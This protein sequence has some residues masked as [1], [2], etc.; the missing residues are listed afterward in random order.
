MA[1]WFQKLIGSDGST[2]LGINASAPVGTEGGAVTRPV[3]R[4]K[5]TTETTAN[6]GIAGVYT[7]SWNDTQLEGSL[8][9]QATARSDQV[10]AAAGFS[11]EESDDTADA[12]F[13]TVAN[14]VSVAASATTTL[15]APIK[16]RY[17]RIK[18][19]NGGV[20]TTAFKI[21]STSRNMA[22][23]QAGDQ[24]VVI[25]AQNSSTTNLASAATFTGV[26]DSTL[27]SGAIQVNLFADQ[28]CTIN[29]DQSQDGTNW[30]TTDTYTYL[31][32]SKA[33]D[34]GRTTQ[35]TGAYVRVRVTNNGG[36]STTSFR[37][38]TVL[39]PIIEAMPRSLNQSGSLKTSLQ[40][41]GGL[42]YYRITATSGTMAAA[43]AASAQVF[44][45]RWTNA[46]NLAIIT[47]VRVSVRAL[48]PFTA[49]T[50]TD[51]GMDLYKTTSVSAG[52]GGTTLGAP[53]KM[54]TNMATSLVANINI[55]TTAALTAATTVDASAICASLGW[56]Q[57]VNPAAATEE[58]VNTAPILLFE[59]KL[60]NG[61]HP[62]V[63][64]TNEGIVIRNRTIWPAAGTAL[65][66]VEIG[67]HEAPT[68]N[69]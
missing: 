27:G 45:F 46:S 17:W 14:N 7:G 25:S 20:A 52:G 32:S 44:Q 42:G 24:A 61:E 58:V 26:D 16:R 68:Y 6:L 19:T 3:L 60:S 34:S 41:M 35:A 59:P 50:L 15:D 62:L 47:Y 29:I 31:A 53:S 12:N 54:R 36:S 11:I 43:L 48:T 21:I 69:T 64:Q 40:P 38:Q 65:I 23:I 28:N 37:L 22:P 4:V 5:T 9:V 67:W 13:L 56:P 57:R 63:L 66:Q 1:N 49:A 51:F 30:D 8:F 39:A 10:S 55:S 2:I 33:S 18:Y